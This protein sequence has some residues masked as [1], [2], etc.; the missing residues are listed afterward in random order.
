[1]FNESKYTTWYW[2]IIENARS[3]PR[4]GYVERHHI[5]PKSMN[6]S[7]NADN[8]VALSFREHFLC[9]WL[10]TKMCIDL[11]DKRKMFYALTRMTRKKKLVV[12]AGWQYEQVRRAARKAARDRIMSE[13]TKLK[14]RKSWTDERKAALW[15]PER[16]AARSEKYTGK[17]NPF[18]EKKHSEEC[19]KNLS[20]NNPAKREDVREKMRKPKSVKRSFR[21]LDE[22]TKQKIS[23]TLMGRLESDETKGKK[24]AA[25]ADLVWIHDGINKPKQIKLD[26]FDEASGWKR[27]RGPKSNW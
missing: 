24:R 14:L 23:A 15:T 16:R 9:H 6:G 7:N 1:M 4:E 10:L 2:S 11:R 27:G 8:L 25:K 26:T 18:F 12:L 22:S 21:A 13:E 3:N 20:E 17:N 5:I 19:K